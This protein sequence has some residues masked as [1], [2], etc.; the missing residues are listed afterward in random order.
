ML[1]KAKVR[2]AIVGG[3][4]LWHYLPASLQRFTRDVDFAIP[5]GKRKALAATIVA[6]GYRPRLLSIGGL[7]IRQGGLSIDFVDRHPELSALFE[8][9]IDAAYR[10]GPKL[11]IG[12]QKAPVVP[13]NYLVAL[14]L[15]SGERRDERDVQA[16]LFTVTTPQYYKLRSFIRRLL[17]PDGALRLDALARRIQHPAVPQDFYRY[18]E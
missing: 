3:I 4:A 15:A 2:F 13:K 11:R 10:R 1:S 5:Y 18:D 16:L 8:D 6:S 17:G 14:K 9:A 12:G 7:A